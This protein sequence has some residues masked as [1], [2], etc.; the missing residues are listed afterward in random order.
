MASLERVQRNLKRYRASVLKAAVEGR[1]VPTEAETARAEGRSYEPASV[2][3]K[4]ILTERRRRWE[5]AE[6]AKMKAKGKAPRDDKWKAKYVAPVA[7]D[8]SE[9]P[10]LPEGWCW[11]SIDVVCQS[12]TDGDH[13][14]PPQ[15]KEGV[16]FLVIGNVA[17]GHIE[18]ENT[19]FVPE[20]YYKGLDQI[21]RPACGDIL[22]TVTGSFGIPVSVETDRPF[23]V[24]RHIAILRPACSMNR[25]YLAH[26]L[27][28]QGVLQQAVNGATGTAQK[29]VALKVLRG[30]AVP[31]P[32]LAEQCLIADEVDRL[33]SMESSADAAVAVNESCCFRLRQS[34]L[35]SAFEGRLV[36]QDPTDE[37]AFASLERIRA[38]RE[39]AVDKPP[40]RL[41]RPRAKKKD[42]T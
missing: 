30:I 34:I 26:A 37:P 4:R 16:P 32:P 42:R 29:T 39:S 10:D 9:F 33:L 28:S 21:R 20:V 38:E 13:V 12:V 27:A 7:P 18:F 31:V 6:L 23:C 17:G 8:T 40:R 15:T 25:R 19:R 1:L 3:L 2:L 5:E 36:K 35:K 41:R 22:Y 11:S 24:Q 14:P